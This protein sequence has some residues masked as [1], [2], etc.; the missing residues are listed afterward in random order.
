V[1]TV[2]TAMTNI[3]KSEDKTG[4]R[5]PV[6]RATVQKT[7]LRRYEYDTALSAG[8]FDH[9]RLRRG[10]FTSI[11]MGEPSGV[12]ELRNIR[13]YSWTRSVN[14]DVAECTITLKNT[15]LTP[16]G[17]APPTEHAND[18]D[19]PGWMTYN[20]GDNHAGT[21][22]WGYT[23]DTGWNGK[24]VPD[25]LVRTYEGYGSDGTVQAANDPNL[26]Q[27]G[28]WL[29]DSAEYT[30]DG[31]ITLN[32]R[33]VGSLLIKQIVFPPVVPY[34]EYPLS[35]SYIHNEEVDGRSPQGG[36]WV[37]LNGQRV[38]AASS[39]NDAY[40]GAG[41]TNPPYGN[42]VGANGGVDGHHANHALEPSDTTYWQSTGQ[43]KYTDFVWWQGDLNE[44]TTSMNAIRV[45]T[46]GGPYKV[47]VSLHNGTKWLGQK[48][49]PYEPGE[50]AG[51][52]NIN[53]DIPFVKIIRPEKGLPEEFLLKRKYGTIAKIR[54]T[55]T[56][57][58]DGGVGTH[59]FRAGLRNVHIY[60]AAN[61]ASLSFGPGTLLKAVGN[62]R[63][64][65][66]IVKWA[67]AWGGFWW[68]PH[69]TGDDF[70][71]TGN[72]SAMGTRQTVEYLSPD[73]KLPKG[74]VWGDFMNSGTH[75][76]DDLTLDL[77]DKKPLMDMIAYVRDILGFVFFIDETGGVVWRMPNWEE[78]GNYMSPGQLGIRSRSRTTDVVTIDENETLISYSTKLS[79]ENM[80]ERIF[81]GNSTGKKGV[82][83]K[84]FNPYPQGFRRTAGWTDQ[85]FVS[86]NECRVMADMIAAR[87]MF[88]YRRS[89]VTIKGYPAIQIDDQVRVFERVTNETY[90]HYVESISSELNMESG[91]WD[92][93]L[94][95]HWLGENPSDAWVVKPTMMDGVT[96]AY[97]NLTDTGG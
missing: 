58:R 96:Q 75:G 70:I 2:S 82:V 38:T 44:V 43:D 74:R 39:S 95:T 14:Q 34:G 97:L 93:T 30:H 9:Q 94:E 7:Q 29:I 12:T 35:W 42:Y 79:S 31:D 69:D 52:V 81:V 65:T 10:W 56:A 53:A 3:W 33:D 51:G 90:Y 80:R 20:R 57:L 88:D 6:V 91:E 47:Y 17:E 64:Y 28:L 50:G 8:D 1:R 77:F 5:R 83:I 19:R 46:Y 89:T 59:P 25:R 23:S 15:E 60:K 85:H 45:H 71:Q 66:D 76:V 24:L 54:L 18:F 61:V 68:P 72:S 87:G 67:C 63:D 37:I 92:Y 55:F 11:V 16:L 86:K 84:G 26:L 36:S 49:I 40:I 41:L 13:S 32:M 4:P 27:S 22:R 73:P 21:T 62:Y 78:K 48:K